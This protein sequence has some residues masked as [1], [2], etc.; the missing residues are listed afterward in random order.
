MLRK[1]SMLVAVITIASMVGGQT[2]QA[3]TGPAIHTW[4]SVDGQ[5]IDAE[6]VKLVYN[7]VHLRKADG[8]IV[9][10]RKDRLTLDDRALVGKLAAERAPKPG[11]LI[12]EDKAEEPEL[13][14]RFVELLGERLIDAH[15]KT[16]TTDRLAGKTVGIYFS[17]G[18][19]PPCRMTTPK[20]AEAY[21]SL[22]ADK[23]PFE[24]VMVSGDRSKKAMFDYMKDF[25]MPWPAL[26]YGS[27]LREKLFEKF[28]VRGIPK[29]VIL[30]PEG[31]LVTE[32]GVQEI[33]AGGAAAFQRW[34]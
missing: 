20:L 9:I 11:K 21:K 25:A 2:E 33:L 4:T 10:I 27:E 7:T 30:D 22:Q 26:P 3:E 15:K 16:S 12:V 19:C 29:L 6:F 24:I 18:W 32:N 31:D 34:Q 14:E 28:N 17:A 23:E 13:P 8:E 1:F 5:T